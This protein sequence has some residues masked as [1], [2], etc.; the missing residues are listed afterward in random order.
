MKNAGVK[1]F[2]GSVGFLLR[3]S[4]ISNL[5]QIMIFQQGSVAVPGQLVCLARLVASMRSP[6]SGAGV[7]MN[8]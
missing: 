5:A 8:K 2:E 3:S 6:Q 7:R 1:N 4:C